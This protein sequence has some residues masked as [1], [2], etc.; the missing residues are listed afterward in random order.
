MTRCGRKRLNDTVGHARQIYRY[1]LFPCL[2]ILH[3][4]LRPCDKL[5][6]I[7]M[8]PKAQFGTDKNV[9][10]QGEAASN[11]SSPGVETD[12]YHLAPPINRSARRSSI[13]K[14]REKGMLAGLQVIAVVPVP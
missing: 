13:S 3:D 11:P 14:V 5:G 2:I 4:R 10:N 6:F 12:K 9:D 1:I 7:Y 8:K